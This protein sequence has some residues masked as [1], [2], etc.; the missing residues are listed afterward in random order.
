MNADLA[1]TPICMSNRSLIS[2]SVCSSLKS[3]SYL[4]AVC[5]F[6]IMHWWK[7]HKGRW[8]R[9]EHQNTNVA[10]VCG[11]ENI[12]PSPSERCHVC[13]IAS[14]WLSHVKRVPSD[15]S[16]VRASINVFLRF[17]IWVRQNSLQW[18]PALAWKGLNSD[19]WEMSA[20]NRRALSKCD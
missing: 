9:R 10:H 16:Q 20:D 19:K 1:F 17:N 2:S 11:Q 6:G 15:P 5:V 13:S 14:I 12:T 3:Q 8:Y 7:R 4:S 18:V